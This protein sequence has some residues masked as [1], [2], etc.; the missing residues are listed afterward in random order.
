MLAFLA[1]FKRGMLCL[2]V[3]MFLFGPSQQIAGAGKY[4]AEWPG[5]SRNLFFVSLKRILVAS[6]DCLALL[7]R[8]H[9]R[10]LPFQGKPLEKIVPSVSPVPRQRL[11]R[12]YA[13]RNYQGCT[14]EEQT[15]WYA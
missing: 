6:R 5:L 7:F 4:H 10:Q 2:P 8:G 3:R 15:K 1:R 14:Y 9:D 12:E 11:P 13:R